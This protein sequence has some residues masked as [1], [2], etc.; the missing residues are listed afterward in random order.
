MDIQDIVDE[1]SVSTALL[2]RHYEDRHV[3]SEPRDRSSPLIL[4]RSNTQHDAS[5]D[6]VAALL[7]DEEE[8]KKQE[9]VLVRFVSE[10][11]CALVYRR[12]T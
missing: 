12:L 9:E 3:V 11:T 7:Q 10:P 6:E 2:Q 8:K 5:E 4:T 1:F